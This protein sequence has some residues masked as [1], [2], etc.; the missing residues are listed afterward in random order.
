M[1][2]DVNGSRIMSPR[3]TC[4][5]CGAALPTDLPKGLCARCALREMLAEGAESAVGSAAQEAEPVTP[6]VV[7]TGADF[8]DYQLVEEIARGGMGVVYK[9]RQRS[10]QRM[11]A[12]KM[13]LAGRLAGKEVTQRF[14]GEAAAAGTLQHP[15]IVAIHE[16]GMHRGQHFFS[17]DYVEGQN[18]AQMVGNRPLAP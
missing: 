17:M 15:N 3:F 18:L 9:A 2:N 14:R 4:P 6:A 5:E 13:I 16:I 12:I 8:G 10:L 1:R 11:V 7:E